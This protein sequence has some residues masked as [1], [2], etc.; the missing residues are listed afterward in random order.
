MKIRQLFILVAIL[1]V[2]FGCSHQEHY[3]V[4]LVSDS[5]WKVFNDNSLANKRINIQTHIEID[6]LSH[7]IT[8]I[9]ET[10]SV[11][12]SIDSFEFSEDSVLLINSHIDDDLS[13]TII[14]DCKNFNERLIVKQQSKKYVGKNYEIQYRLTHKDGKELPL[15]DI[16]KNKHFPFIGI[17]MDC[18][19]VEMSKRLVDIGFDYGYHTQKW[20]HLTGYIYGVL[21]D[22]CIWETSLSHMVYK[23]SISLHKPYS[24]TDVMTLL[25]NIVLNYGNLQSPYNHSWFFLT[26]EE[27]RGAINIYEIGGDLDIRFEDKINDELNLLELR[28]S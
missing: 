1:S 24:Q 3:Q 19:A 28:K 23:I 5:Y 9:Q 10:D 12:Y 13:A 11:V 8:I 26:Y 17:P 18:D 27:P 4:S 2:S 15:T 25:N 22:V 14:A 21:C 7:K 16:A 6:L 20:T